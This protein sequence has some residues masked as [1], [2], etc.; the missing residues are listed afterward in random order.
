MA[1]R[2]LL[3]RGIK[4]EDVNIAADRARAA[5]VFRKTGQMG[6]PVLDIG[7]QIIIG[8]NRM[9]IDAALSNRL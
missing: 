4:F 7:G 6:V 2:Y 8:F 9:G 1:K 5:E 3:E